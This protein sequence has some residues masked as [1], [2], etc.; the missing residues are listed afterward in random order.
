MKN[1]LRIRRNVFIDTLADGTKMDI[2]IDREDGLN[3]AELSRKYQLSD[4]LVRKVVEVGWAQFPYLE[5][6]S[7]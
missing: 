7:E 4:G 1:K 5:D 6:E 2:L 3:F